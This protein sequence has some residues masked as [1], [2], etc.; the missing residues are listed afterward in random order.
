MNASKMLQ[1]LPADGFLSVHHL[2]WVAWLQIAGL[3]VGWG[4]HIDLE[5]NSKLHRY[6]T[7]RS[8]P[9]GR[10]P[11]KFI[12]DGRWTYSADHPTFTV[13]SHFC[14]TF[15]LKNPAAFPLNQLTAV[16]DTV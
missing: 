2:H 12:M 7:T 3:D 5:W 14:P 9:P 6:E 4:Q 11:Y 10:Y 16:Y 15:T 1:R 8:L 13:S